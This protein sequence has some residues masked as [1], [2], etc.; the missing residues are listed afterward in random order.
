MFSHI[1]FSLKNGSVTF[2]AP[3]ITR[4]VVHR[5]LYPWHLHSRGEDLVNTI[6]PV[7]RTYVNTECHVAPR[8]ERPGRHNL[9][10]FGKTEVIYMSCSAFYGSP[11]VYTSTDHGLFFSHWASVDGA[12]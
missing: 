11:T 8:G 1:L 6:L 5:P 9:I 12:Q 4:S 3:C 7:D 2:G 10:G